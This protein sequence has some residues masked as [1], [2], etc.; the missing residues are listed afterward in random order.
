MKTL[1]LGCL[2]LKNLWNSGK[3][4]QGVRILDWNQ[5]LP[6]GSTIETPV[7]T[8]ACKKLRKTDDTHLYQ[9]ST[10]MFIL[11]RFQLK[12]NG[13][14]L[15]PQCDNVLGTTKYSFDWESYNQTRNDMLSMVSPGPKGCRQQRQ[16][17]EEPCDLS[18]QFR[19]IKSILLLFLKKMC[20][21]LPQLH[22][23]WGMCA[24]KNTFV[25]SIPTPIQRGLPWAIC[26]RD[27]QQ[28]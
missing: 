7:D 28:R 20:V 2:S 11:L 15:E 10:F 27:A 1:C 19:D 25:T 4:I 14:Q 23:K 21:F 6:K 5:T 17:Q 22:P 3:A 8:G 26:E 24:M 13:R 12:L 18:H 16:S 9:P